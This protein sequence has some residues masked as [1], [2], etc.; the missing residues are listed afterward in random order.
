MEL[1]TCAHKEEITDLGHGMQQGTCSRCGQIREYDTYHTGKK[2]KIIKVGRLN[3]V[4]V[5][6]GQADIDE[7]LKNN[8]PLSPNLP[9]EEKKRIAFDAKEIGLK[10][11][12]EKYGIPWKTI[13][14]WCMTFCYPRTHNSRKIENKM[15]T[16]GKKKEKGADNRK[17]ISGCT[18]CN[19]IKQVEGILYCTSL[20]CPSHYPKRLR[21][22]YRNSFEVRETHENKNKEKLP[23][24]PD[25]NPSWDPIV[26]VEW[27]RVYK[28]LFQHQIKMKS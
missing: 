15:T 5:S 18:G 8:T 23:T 22:P 28:D 26:Q 27:L 14:A 24:L 6:T 16:E 12:G 25:F 9:Y 13:R 2:P 17:R 1:A 3:G 11:A 7:S 19:F 21:P 20:K 4:P 10:Q